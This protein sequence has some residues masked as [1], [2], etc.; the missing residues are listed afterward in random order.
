MAQNLLKRKA[1]KKPRPPMKM[2]TSLRHLHCLRITRKTKAGTQTKIVMTSG[3]ARARMTRR[4]V[5]AAGHAHGTVSPA[6]AAAEAEAGRG[7]RASA[8]RAGVRVG[9]GGGEGQRLGTK[10]E[11]AAETGLGGAGAG[12]ESAA[13]AAPAGAAAGAADVAL[14]QTVMWGGM[15]LVPGGHPT[16]AQ[17][18][19]HPV[20]H[21]P[22]PC[23]VACLLLRTHTRPWAQV[24]LTLLPCS[25]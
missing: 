25:A 10:G 5:A 1:M 9:T 14:A 20:H 3:I 22:H 18:L 21:L 16:L 24:P 11:A 6:G 8:V 17:V 12:T 4:T 15:S 13:S 2:M 23:Q 19:H 7:V